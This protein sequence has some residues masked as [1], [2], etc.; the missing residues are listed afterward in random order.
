MVERLPHCECKLHTQGFS[1]TKKRRSDITEKKEGGGG[2]EREREKRD[3]AIGGDIYILQ[4]DKGRTEA[5]RQGH[6]PQDENLPLSCIRFLM[7][8]RGWVTNT[9]VHL[10]MDKTDL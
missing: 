7:R 1:K 5:T 10:H 4:S 2:R 8:S 6:T 3:I 9:A